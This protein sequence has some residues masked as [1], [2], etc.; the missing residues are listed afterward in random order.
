M[1]CMPLPCPVTKD[2]F[3]YYCPCPVK[4]FGC[5]VQLSHL[6]KIQRK[7]HIFFLIFFPLLLG[8]YFPNSLRHSFL[9]PILSFYLEKN[10]TFYRLYYLFSFLRTDHKCNCFSKTP[11]KQK[12]KE[13]QAIFSQAAEICIVTK[14]CR[15]N[16]AT[17]IDTFSSVSSTEN[18]R[19]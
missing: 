6:W 16:A 12:Q 11:S 1:L 4:T 19:R 2:E 3:H 9:S 8:L 13:L 5:T 7:T 10:Q 18:Y 15:E 17:D 14:K